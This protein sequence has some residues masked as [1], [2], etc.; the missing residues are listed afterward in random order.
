VRL[1]IGQHLYKDE[2]NELRMTVSGGVASYPGDGVGHPD[3]LIKR[4]DEA[5][6][7]AKTTGRDRIIRASEVPSEE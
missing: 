4:A 6:Y 5:L 7:T 1:A 3:M 2:A